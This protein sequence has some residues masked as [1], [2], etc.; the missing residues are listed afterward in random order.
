LLVD[1]RIAG[2]C[3]LILV[4]LTMRLG[5]AGAMKKAPSVRK[6]AGFD[7]LEEAVGR[8]TEMG[9][10]VFYTPGY[11]DVSGTVAAA[12]LAGVDVLGYV[13][14]LTSRYDTK[15]SVTVGHANTYA[16]SQEVVK[17]AYISEGKGQ[18]FSEDMIRFVSNQQFAFT[19]ASLGVVQREKPATALY[20]GYFAAEAVILAEAAVAIGAISIAGCTNIFQIPFFAA[21][22]DY[23]MIGEEFLAAGAFISKDPQR[24]GGIVGQDYMKLI[25]ITFILVGAIMASAGSKALPALMVH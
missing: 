9:R 14:R 22:C 20:I 23:T 11:E 4:F 24:T 5:I 2:L 15:L 21:A 8:A 17:N 12:S 3:T 6:I 18:A 13:S 7:A 19:A 16:L 25:V 10:P 1:G